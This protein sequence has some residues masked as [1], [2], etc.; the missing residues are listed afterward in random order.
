MLD[1]AVLGELREL[2]EMTDPGL[3]AELVA[4]YLVDA[5]GRVEE[6]VRSLAEGDREGVGR[7]AH[8]LKSSS[9]YLGALG[10]AGVCREIEEA[11][12]GAGVEGLA[13][14]VEETQ[15]EFQRVCEA[16]RRLVGDRT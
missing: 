15:D 5:P 10:L 2:E 4:E 7:A 3:V 6:L 8:S 16:L 13:R 14:R 9:A 1:A 12:R 11:A